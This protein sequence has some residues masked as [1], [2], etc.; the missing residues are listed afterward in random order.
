M[1]LT[2]AFSLDYLSWDG[3]ESVTYESARRP[4]DSPALSRQ[5]R[6]PS[7]ADMIPVAKR[8]ALT[9]REL[10]ASLGSYTA[11]D[12]V[13]L[14]PA[15]VLPS[16]LS[17]KPGDV[18]VDSAAARW[19]A[20][21]VQTN[22]GEQTY[23]LTCRNLTLVFELRDSIDIERASVIYDGA[24]A[25]I[26]QFPTGPGP[27]GGQVLY[28]GLVCRVQLATQQ[29]AEERGIRGFR[30]TYAIIVEREVTVTNEDRIRLRTASTDGLAAGSY[31]EIRDYHQAQ[32]ID[33]LSVIAAERAV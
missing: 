26:K 18:V 12:R 31:L 10:A 4:T 28:T 15:A 24:G 29:I 6:N 22:K 14:L 5:L 1:D 9:R 7:Q 13:W 23:R 25:A 2:A 32:T 19:T 27:R 8:R 17:P 16:W 30:G 20:L 21:E 3:T 11:G 33:N